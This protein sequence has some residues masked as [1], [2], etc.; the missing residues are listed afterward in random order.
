MTELRFLGIHVWVPAGERSAEFFAHHL[1]QD[2]KE[3]FKGC[4]GAIEAIPLVVLKVQRAY[5]V[6]V[7]SGSLELT[8][9]QLG[10]LSM[11]EVKQIQASWRGFDLP[12]GF[13]AIDPV[14]RPDVNQVVRENVAN[15][16]P[17]DDELE[18]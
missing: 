11:A 13:M 18:P 7:R 15:S 16:R 4:I 14:D 3:D 9:R 17:W 10:A 6:V 2:A 8:M 12:L 5:D 1:P